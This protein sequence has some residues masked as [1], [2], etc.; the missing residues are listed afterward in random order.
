MP[1]DDLIR[2]ESTLSVKLTE[3]YTAF[4]IDSE[5]KLIP[6]PLSIYSLPL[7]TPGNLLTGILLINCSIYSSESCRY[8]TES[9]F[10]ILEHNL[11]SNLLTAMPIVAVYGL[12]ASFIS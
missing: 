4:D 7:P 5:H 2:N 10:S 9:L 11:A 12:M 3:I 8:L 1:K 6:S